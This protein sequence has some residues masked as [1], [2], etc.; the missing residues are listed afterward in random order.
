MFTRIE[1]F[2]FTLLFANFLFA[3]IFVFKLWRLLKS[4]R[5]YKYSVKWEKLIASVKEGKTTRD[6]AQVFIS[7]VL[8]I[9]QPFSC[10]NSVDTLMK[11]SREK[12]WPIVIFTGIVEIMENFILILGIIL[13][14]FTNQNPEK[15]QNVNNILT[16]YNS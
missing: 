3:V 15:N 12:A 11:E 16:V 1:C 6:L 9:F 10:N 7:A 4:F 13:K 2:L 5:Y 8:N 14:T